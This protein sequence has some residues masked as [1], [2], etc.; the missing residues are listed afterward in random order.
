MVMGSPETISG[1]ID[2]TVRGMVSGR[3]VAV[4]FSGGLDSG[5]I[6]GLS[7][8][9][10]DSVTFYVAGVRGCH[11]I[12][13][14]KSA[15]AEMGA[16]LEVIEV[17]DAVSVIRDQMEVTGCTNPLMLAFSSPLFCVLRGC[18][19]DYV[20]GGTGADEVFGGY[21]KYVAVPD[22]ELKGRMKEDTG[23]YWSETFPHEE[24]IA[25]VFG[26]TILRPYL[27]E[28]LTSFVDSLPPEVIRPR[29]EDRK[30]LLCDAAEELGF[31]FLASRPKKAAQYGSGILD[32]VKAVCRERGI[33]YN[34]LVSELSK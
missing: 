26:K 12:E 3:R 13:A 23:R 1:I 24:K 14:A 5:L 18:S 15:A 29:P 17:T 6:G 2:D 11:D 30:R 28:G 32:A 21:N 27:D 31:G 20:I 22:E 34:Q 19:E 8:R 16:R 25:S 33:E 9:Y 7:M 10:A 4:A